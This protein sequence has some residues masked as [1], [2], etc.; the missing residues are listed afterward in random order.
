[1]DET[2]P[3]ENLY[4]RDRVETTSIQTPAEMAKAPESARAE[5]SAPPPQ[6]D[7]RGQIAGLASNVASSWPASLTEFPQF[8][9]KN[10]RAWITLAAGVAGLVLLGMLTIRATDWLKQRRERRHEQAIATVTPDHLIARCGQAA[11]DETKEVFPILMRT[12]SYQRGG[13]KLVISFSRTA[14]ESSDW[15]FLSMKDAAGIN[16]DTPEAKIAALPCLDSRK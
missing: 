6:N 8:L 13:E 7:L 16:Y 4:S 12:M 10:W 5:T 11:Q 3:K 2:K 9:K 14:E 1:M 15:V